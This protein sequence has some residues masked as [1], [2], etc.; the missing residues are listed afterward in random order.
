MPTVA[1]NG[2]AGPIDIGGSTLDKEMPA[3]DFL[4][5][6]DIAAVANYVRTNW[7]NDASR[8]PPGFPDQTADGG[9]GNPNQSEKRTKAEVHAYRASLK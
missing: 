4:S 5:D 9:G 1:L 8:T 6:A 7:G 2:L 3:F